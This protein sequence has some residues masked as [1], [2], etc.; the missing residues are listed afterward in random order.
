MTGNKRPI[1]VDLAIAMVKQFAQ[2]YKETGLTGLSVLANGR[3]GVQVEHE[4]LPGVASPD[5]WKWAERNRPGFDP[6]RAHVVVDGVEFLALFTDEEK[7]EV[8]SDD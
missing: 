3:P 8:L 5:A 6:W 7:A 4:S 1:D 2:E